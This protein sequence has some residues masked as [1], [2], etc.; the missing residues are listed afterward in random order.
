M[1]KDELAADKE[2]IE[3]GRRAGL[4]EAIKIAEQLLGCRPDEIVN[5]I[6]AAKE[7]A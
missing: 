4:E 3:Y 7:K 5:A 1:S 6:R 2:L